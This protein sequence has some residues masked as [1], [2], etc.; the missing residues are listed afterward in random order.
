MLTGRD[1]VAAPVPAPG[2]VEFLP[3]YKLVLYTNFRPKVDGSDGAIWD[4]IRLIPF[5][6]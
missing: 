3:E 4:R 6:V 5:T 2:V 1:K